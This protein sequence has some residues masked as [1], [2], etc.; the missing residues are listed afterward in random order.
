MP[1]YTVTA[2]VMS[3]TPGMPITPITYCRDASALEALH[4]ATTIL[5]DHVDYEAHM[6]ILLS[7]TI[8]VHN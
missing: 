6:P 2:N 4:A 8:D 5:R 1:T 3:K 7:V